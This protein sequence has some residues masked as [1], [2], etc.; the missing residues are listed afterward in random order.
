MAQAKKCDR[1]GSLY[2]P[3]RRNEGFYKIN[4]VILADISNDGTHLTRGPSRDFCPECTDEFMRW[5]ED[6]TEDSV[7]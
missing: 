6:D 5:L 3:H 1:C 7:K 4:G 2:A